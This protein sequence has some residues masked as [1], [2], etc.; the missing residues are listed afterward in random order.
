MS[1]GLV[2]VFFGCGGGVWLVRW[3]GL[4]CGFVFGVV[5]VGCLVLFWYL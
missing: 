5:F 3:I 2:M 4:W 1:G